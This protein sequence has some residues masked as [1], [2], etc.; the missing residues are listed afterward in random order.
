VLEFIS[1][2][3]RKLQ[4]DLLVIPVCED[5]VLHQNKRILEIIAKA[6]NLPEFSGKIKEEL[7][8][9]NLPHIAA[10]RVL[11][12][13]L[14][15]FKELDAEAWRKA[16]GRC[17]KQAQKKGFRD[18]LFVVPPARSTSI[19]MA[20][21]LQ[22]IGE[23]AVLGNHIFDQYQNDTKETP[24]TSFKCLVSSSAQKAYAAIAQQTQ[25]VCLAANQAREWVSIPANDKTPEILAAQMVQQA[26]AAGLKTEVLSEKEMQKLGFG[27]LLSVSVGSRNK[28]QLVILQHRPDTAATK[29]E[30]IA[31][32][33]KG[34]TFDTGG[35]NLKPTG[36]L[37][38]MKMDMA[39]GAAVAATLI[40]ASQLNIPLHIMGAIP[41]VENMVS[42][43][44][45]RPGDIVKSYSGKTVEIGNTDA[46]GRLILAD[47]CAYIIKRY[48]PSILIDLATLTGAC[49][50]ALGEQIAGLFTADEPLRSL[51]C[52]A[53]EKSFERCWPM[54]LPDDYRDR[55]K[56]DFADMQNIG[57]SR[58]G[59]A[60]IAALFL[61][62]FTEGVRWAHIDIAGPAY[63]K[64][65]SD[66]GGAGGTGFGV[67]LLHELFRQILSE[68]TG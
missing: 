42:G 37:E 31:L 65:A 25:I 46:E 68:G 6:D 19:E 62:H 32:V 11:L 47:T 56:S 14:G 24:L 21:L 43:Q 63:I 50:V 52:Q 57:K 34:V 4:P 15:P 49:M 26:K 13:G 40:S 55:L 33:G 39:G 29:K 9:Y 20:V 44:A 27:A 30:L 60:I 23:G 10:E 36:S 35:I 59:G 61:S 22:A 28:P 12:I 64:K 3:L 66:Y 18:A 16:V 53:G 2:D 41:L 1:G 58:Y 54:P 7:L 51:I 5:K 48:A 38:Q 67:R 45:T 8:L 17:V